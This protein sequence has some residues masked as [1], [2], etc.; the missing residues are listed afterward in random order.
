MKTKQ[1]TILILFELGR[2]PDEGFKV[3]TGLQQAIFDKNCG[4]GALLS[5]PLKIDKKTTVRPIRVILKANRDT[6][7]TS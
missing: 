6:S 5:Q 4:S 1:V 2:S 3:Q 7:L